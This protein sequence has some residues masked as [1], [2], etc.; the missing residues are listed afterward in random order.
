MSARDRPP[1]LAARDLE[2]AFPRGGG[3]VTAVRGLCYELESG[4]TLA[5]I[6]ESGCGKTV[7]CRALL[8]L[9]PRG[10]S[11]TGSVRLEGRELLGLTDAELRRYRGAG[12]AMVFQDPSQSLNPTMR[13]GDQI[14]EALRRRERLDGGAARRAALEL[15]TRMELPTPAECLRAFPHQL[16]GGMRQRVMIAIAVACRPK[17]LVA[18]EITASLDA[19]THRRIMRLLLDLQRA[20]GM[21]LIVVS[22]DLRSVASIAD[23]VLVMREG[24]AVEYA[25]MARVLHA[26]RTPYA[27]TLLAAACCRPGGVETEA[28][29][30]APSRTASPRD[31]VLDVRGLRQTYAPPGGA[32]RFGGGSVEALA[33]VSFTIERGETL[34]LVGE[35]GSGKTTLARTLFQLPPPRSGSVVL[36]GKDLTRLGGRRLAGQRRHM[37]MVFQDPSGSLNPRWRTAAIVAEP[38]LAQ[39][40]G[41]R[42]ERRRR[43]AEV[44]ELVGL[45]FAT[46]GRRFPRELSGGQCQRVAIARALAPHPALLVCDEAVSAL[47]ALVRARILDLFDRLRRELSLSCLFISHDLAVVRR[48]SDRVAVLHRGRLCELA[49]AD[50]LYRRPRHPYSAALIAADER[51]PNDEQR[52]PLRVDEGRAP[53]AHEA[54][55]GCRLRTSCPRARDLCAREAPRLRLLGDDHLVACHFPLEGAHDVRAA[56]SAPGPAVA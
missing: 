40:M 35:S 49:P 9:L 7:A 29:Q 53:A 39:G 12:I 34:G 24:R 23:D 10:A 54:A 11:I 50:S 52:P 1:L 13:V 16:S 37:Q 33:D 4:R 27:K 25:P 5:I 26:P 20:L 45:P 22:H 42:R 46:Y 47:D 14:V 15:L 2:V 36:L 8:K 30:T 3:A 55:R 56:R 51:L 17:V 31:A 38:L 28:S 18:D 32:L 19:I 41:D 6:G 43:V 48:I 44:L 21:A